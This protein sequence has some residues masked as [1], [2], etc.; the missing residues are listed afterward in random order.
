MVDFGGCDEV[1]ME[2]TIILKERA[3]LYL[4]PEET[5]D[6]VMDNVGAKP[7]NTSYGNHYRFYCV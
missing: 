6:C 2:Y 5:I 4:L 3:L 1:W 7:A